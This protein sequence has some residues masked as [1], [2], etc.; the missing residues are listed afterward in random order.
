MDIK[1]WLVYMSKSEYIIIIII[2]M[3]III[4]IITQSQ[5]Y[6]QTMNS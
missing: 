2:I 4:I 1:L 5:I 6:T 3:I